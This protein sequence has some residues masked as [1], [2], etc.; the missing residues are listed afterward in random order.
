MKFV[1]VFAVNSLVFDL[2]EGV[3][4]GKTL[5]YNKE[6]LA[7]G[8]DSNQANATI[9]VMDEFMSE[10]FATKKDLEITELRLKSEILDLRH[11]MNNRFK[12]FEFK[13]ETLH[14]KIVIKLSGIMVVL[15][16]AVVA[17]Q[18]IF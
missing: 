10:K 18:K 17:A 14:D 11:E 16:G 1:T 7:A 3:E 6:L 12:E 15:V 5:R 9:R 4:M 13:L 2:S 8:F